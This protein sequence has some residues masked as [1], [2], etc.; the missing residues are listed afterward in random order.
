MTAAELLAA[1]RR[2][3]CRPSV[4]GP[5]LVLDNEPPADLARAIGVLLTGLRAL[6]TGNRWHGIDAATGHPC[7]P[8]PGRA[9][10]ALA[11]GALDPRAKL[12]RSVRLLAVESAGEGWD[13]LPPRAAETFPELF[14]PAPAVAFRGRR[15]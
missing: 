11:F 12:P 6:L 14:E 8:F 13:R 7:G 5:D 15:P 1:L 2:A 4:E 9:A 3:G 10:G